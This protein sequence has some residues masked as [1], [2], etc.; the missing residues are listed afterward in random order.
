MCHA[1]KFCEVSIIGPILKIRKQIH[2]KDKR[3]SLNG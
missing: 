2:Q 3:S 1:Y